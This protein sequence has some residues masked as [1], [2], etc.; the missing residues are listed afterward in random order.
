MSPIRQESTQMQTEPICWNM[1]ALHNGQISNDSV[2]SQDTKYT[3]L[4]LYELPQSK[5]YPAK[6]KTFTRYMSPIIFQDIDLDI[7]GIPLKSLKE[8]LSLLQP[9]IVGGMDRVFR[10]YPNMENINLR[11]MWPGYTPRYGTQT[12]IQFSIDTTRTTR[13]MIAQIVGQKVAQFMAVSVQIQIP[14][15]KIRCSWS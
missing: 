2:S 5:Y 12:A 3:T 15:S 11:I 10:R 1:Y 14:L 9:N 13:A 8:D 7:P 4:P 6:R